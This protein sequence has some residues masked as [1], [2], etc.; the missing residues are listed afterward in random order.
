MQDDIAGAFGRHLDDVQSAAP[1]DHRRSPWRRRPNP[2]PADKATAVALD[3]RS[4]VEPVRRA[5]QMLKLRGVDVAWGRNEKMPPP[6][7]LTS[8]TSRSSRACRG[9]Q[10]VRS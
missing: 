3:E 5:E 9:Q 4:K 10:T 1:F 8:T 2:V 6:S 7:L